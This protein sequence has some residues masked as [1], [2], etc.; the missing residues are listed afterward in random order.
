MGSP[1]FLRVTVVSRALRRGRTR[2]IRPVPALFSACVAPR[3]PQLLTAA[4]YVPR[5]AFLDACFK[6]R[7][8]R[9]KG[10]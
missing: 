1:I 6:G 4:R 8:S 9:I 2:G 7:S 3:R 10:T 5:A